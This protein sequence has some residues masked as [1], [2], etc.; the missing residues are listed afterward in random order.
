[1]PSSSRGLLRSPAD[2][3]ARHASFHRGRGQQNA[4][5]SGQ[6]LRG[7]CM[8]PR[9]GP[10]D[11]PR[12]PENLDW[13]APRRSRAE[14]PRKGD[15]RRAGSTIGACSSA[16][17]A[18]RNESRDREWSCAR[19]GA[20]QD[21]IDASVEGCRRTGHGRAGPMIGN[22]ASAAG[23]CT[24]AHAAGH[25]LPANGSWPARAAERTRWPDAPILERGPRRRGPF[26]EGAGRRGLRG[27]RDRD[28]FAATAIAPVSRA[29]QSP[30][31]N[32]RWKAASARRSPVSVRTRDL[33]LLTGSEISP[34]A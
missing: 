11:A 2:D 24:A 9:R 29:A 18:M 30:G 16:A 32:R 4:R 7:Q 23:R 28:W 17:A 27:G 14:S 1:M 10:S 6:R 34:L 19:D 21:Q 25:S 22:R 13:P 20:V 8:R 3:G 33:A 26:R 15:G 5:A 12:A 31:A